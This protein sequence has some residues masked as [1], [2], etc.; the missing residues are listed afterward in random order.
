MGNLIISYCFWIE[1]VEIDNCW[2]IFLIE[3]IKFLNFFNMCLKKLFFY[4]KYGSLFF[5]NYFEIEFT[6]I[7][8]S[9][10][11]Y[12]YGYNFIL[13]LFNTSSVC[14][15]ELYLDCLCVDTRSFFENFISNFFF[16][17]KVYISVGEGDRD[18]FRY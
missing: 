6:N 3:I 1:V 18:F 15:K 14:I 10:K 5:F 13:K 11:C 7:F 9:F 12:V 16:F 2:I 4:Y 8:E 17:E